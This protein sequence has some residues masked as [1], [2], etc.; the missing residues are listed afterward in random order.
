[1][2]KQ[3]LRPLFDNQGDFDKFI[4]DMS[5]ES[6]MQA[7]TGKFIGNSARAARVAEDNSG[8]TGTSALANAATIGGAL[9]GG[10][11]FV[12]ASRVPALFSALRNVGG[13]NNPAVN[14]SMARML[15]TADPATN[16][17][18]LAQILA[19]SRYPSMSNQLALPV[20]AAAGS[21]RWSRYVLAERSRISS[22]APRRRN[23]RPHHDDPT[24]SC[25]TANDEID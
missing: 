7:N 16:A 24:P 25:W 10:E 22:R 14:A 21:I 3:Q 15:F 2:M 4:G 9:L 12:A 5:N 17:Q 6:M 8:H 19:Q 11:P 20:A 18:T 13:A 1:M 23:N